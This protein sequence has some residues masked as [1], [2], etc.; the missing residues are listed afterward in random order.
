M[1]KTKLSGFCLL[2]MIFH[3]FQIRYETVQPNCRKYVIISIFH[4]KLDFFS[5][6]RSNFPFNI[7]IT[8]YSSSIEGG[9]PSVLWGH[10]IIL[11]CHFKGFS[12][13]HTV[14][15]GP[16]ACICLLKRVHSTAWILLLYHWTITVVMG[17]L[18]ISFWNLNIEKSGIILPLLM[19]ICC[20]V[21]VWIIMEKYNMKMLTFW[22][23][24]FEQKNLNNTGHVLNKIRAVSCVIPCPKYAKL[25]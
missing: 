4:C 13:G 11:F 12:G 3:V 14:L 5:F 24:V 18:L 22:Q 17:K 6:S 20:L 21:Y 7:V 25:L 19:K 23:Y 8:F 2:K 10:K 9:R 16:Q 1:K 15:T